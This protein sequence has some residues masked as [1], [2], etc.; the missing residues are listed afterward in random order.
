[1]QVTAPRRPLF[2]RTHT[3]P[4][5]MHICQHK[6]DYCLSFEEERQVL[7]I[8]VNIYIYLHVNEMSECETNEFDGI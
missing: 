3:S 8:H 7:F 2:E 6:Y 1:M 5:F 4:H